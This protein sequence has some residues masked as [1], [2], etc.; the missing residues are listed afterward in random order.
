QGFATPHPWLPS[1]AAPRLQRTSLSG[2]R[3]PAVP[4]FVE[5][6]FHNLRR[7][8]VVVAVADPHRPR[9]D[10]EQARPTLPLSAVRKRLEVKLLQPLEFRTARLVGDSLVLHGALV[11]VGSPANDE[12]DLGILPEVLHFASRFQRVEKDL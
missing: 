12:G 1:V 8:P 10:V 6:E 2:R 9:A 4:P 7:R 3:S 5:N 11:A